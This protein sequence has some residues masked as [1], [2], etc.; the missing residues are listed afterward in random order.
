MELTYMCVFGENKEFVYHKLMSL[1]EQ[2]KQYRRLIN[3]Q[4]YLHEH[5]FKKN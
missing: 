2:I 3:N 4:K 1:E 5:P